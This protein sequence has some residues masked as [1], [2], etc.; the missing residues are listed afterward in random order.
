MDNY[1]LSKIGQ[2]AVMVP[3]ELKDFTLITKE[4]SQVSYYGVDMNTDSIYVQFKN[5]GKGY[6]Y[7]NQP[8]DAL[9]A[10]MEAASVGSWVIQNLSKPKAEFIKVDYSIQP[11]TEDV[12]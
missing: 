5:N 12:K 8:I 9:K 7:P 3:N 10:I 2:Q 1:F 6:L 11:V 4:S